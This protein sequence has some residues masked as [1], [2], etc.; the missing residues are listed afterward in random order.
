MPKK[1]T[2]VWKDIIQGEISIQ[3]STHSTS[4]GDPVLLNFH[5][6]PSPLLRNVVDDYFMKI[7][8]VIE[9]NVS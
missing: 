9:R 6:L 7:S 5:G 1:G 4:G 3:N 2:T 8:H